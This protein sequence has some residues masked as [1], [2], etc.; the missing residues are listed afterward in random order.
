MSVHS[1]NC[2]RDAASPEEVD[3][4]CAETFEVV[5]RVIRSGGTLTDPQ[6][7]WAKRHAGLPE[8]SDTDAVAVWLR[9]RQH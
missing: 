9:K 3:A 5:T 8:G 7:K 4:A 2:V 1:E 6:L